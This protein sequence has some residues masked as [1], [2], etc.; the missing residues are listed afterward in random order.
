ML[1]LLAMIAVF[2]ADKPTVSLEESCRQAAAVVVVETTNDGKYRII[3]ILHDHSG[4][5]LNKAAVID[6]DLRGMVY[7]KGRA[8]ILF[9]KTTADSK[10][11]YAAPQMRTE[12]GKDVR[13]RVRKILAS[14]K[15]R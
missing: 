14:L 8:Y 5:Q 11:Y 4:R 9:L 7:D 6:V 15:P 13:E 3:E 1:S 12:D 2:A 10:S